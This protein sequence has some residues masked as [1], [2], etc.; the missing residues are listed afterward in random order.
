MS[1]SQLLENTY[2][3]QIDVCAAKVC[4]NEVPNGVRT[5]DGVLVAI[6]GVQE[7]GVF[8]GNE[9]ARLLV[10]PQLLSLL[11]FLDSFAINWITYNVLVVR[12]QINAAL[13]GLLPNLG[14]GLVLVGLVDDLG[15]NLRARFDQTRVG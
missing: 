5:L 9:I 4:Q 7:P 1:N 10:G 14:D 3:I 13:L 11:V 15:D 8:G 2:I 6:E 12:V